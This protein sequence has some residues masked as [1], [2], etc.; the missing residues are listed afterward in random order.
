MGSQGQHDTNLHSHVE[1]ANDTFLPPGVCPTTF[2]ARLLTV[3]S[4]Q[5]YLR[6]HEEFLTTDLAAKAHN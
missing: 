6:E 4:H 2:Y 5:R 3:P 1:Q